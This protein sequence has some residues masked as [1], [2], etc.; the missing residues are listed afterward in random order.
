MCVWIECVTHVLCQNN[1]LRS[2]HVSE[3]RYRYCIEL[4]IP[5]WMVSPRC[6]N[7]HITAPHERAANTVKYLECG[8]IGF[9]A[10]V[11]SADCGDVLY[12]DEDR[13]MKDATTRETT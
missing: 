12:G 7:S 6:W 10:E 3:S 4:N 2:F 13:G 8:G 1:V 5:G 9:T 11:A